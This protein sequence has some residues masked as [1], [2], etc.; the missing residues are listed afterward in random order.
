MEFIR[1][2]FP[3]SPAREVFLNIRQFTLFTRDVR[4]AIFIIW[5]CRLYFLILF[6]YLSFRRRGEGS[7]QYPKAISL[8]QFVWMDSLSDQFPDNLIY[9]G[10]CGGGSCPFISFV[11]LDVNT[12]LKLFYPYICKT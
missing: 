6:D 7:A 11:T 9:G 2:V 1:A 12:A 3:I 4:G 8:D 5:M 10:Y